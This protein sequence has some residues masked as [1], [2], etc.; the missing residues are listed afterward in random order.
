MLLT[1][2]TMADVHPSILIVTEE[3]EPPFWW[4]KV[5]ILNQG[6]SYLNVCHNDAFARSASLKAV[7]KGQMLLDVGPDSPNYIVTEEPSY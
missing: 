6:P 2:T 5:E 3:N 1:G 7:L 4:L